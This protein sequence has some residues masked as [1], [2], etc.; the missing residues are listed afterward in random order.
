VAPLERLRGIWGF[1]LTPFAGGRVDLEALAT[2]VDYQVAGG[3]DV[4]CACGMIA[5]IESL[6]REEWTACAAETLAGRGE[7]PSVVAIPASDDRLE[8]V[9]TAVRLEADALLV[10]PHTGDVEQIETRLRGI[11]SM[12]PGLPL[13]LYHRPPLDLDPAALA[14]LCALEA[15]GGLKDGHR[16]VRRYRRL[17]EAIGERLLWVSAWEDVALPFWALG[18]DAYAPASVAYE[19]AYSRAW[20]ACLT[21]GNVAGARR[22]LAAHAYGMVDLRLSRPGIDV[23]VVKAAMAER[24]LPAGDVRA[25]ALPLT[26][27]ERER[28]QVLLRELDTALAVEATE[29]S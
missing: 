5:E 15:L 8:T 13:V 9:P 26:S 4:I 2:A 7:I 16:D 6:T 19:P 12:A 14:R 21:A 29:A 28:L 25:P 27:P 20:L 17:H 24:G 3:V 18:C 10:L 1:P 11:A 22:L 23:S